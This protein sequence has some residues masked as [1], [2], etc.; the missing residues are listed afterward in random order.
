MRCCSPSRWW[1]S[2]ARTRWVWRRRRRSWSVRGSAPAAGC[3]S[4]TLPRSRASARIATVV[5]DK[6]GTLTK[7]EPEVTDVVVTADG[8]REDGAAR[9]W[10]PRW[11][12]SPSIR[13][14]R[15]SS[16]MP[17]AAR[18]LAWPRDR[19]RERAR[20]RRGRHAS[21]AAGWLSATRRLMEREGIDLGG[22][23]GRRGRA[24]RRRA[25]RG[26][27]GRRRR[28]GRADR[29]RRRT[30]ARPPRAAVAA[31]HGLGRRGRSC[32]PATTRHRRPDRRRTRHRQ[33]HRR[34]AAR[35]QGRQGR[36]A[37]AGRSEGGHGG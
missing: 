17:T 5:M 1:S 35:R 3:C 6:T 8:C 27:G 9:P 36:R 15:R 37:A 11:S 4:R 29:D 30:R 32:S 20:S 13:W 25:H 19:L 7:G 33:R 23:A 14:R 10:R 28:G 24:G 2:P 26:H 12:G 22:L 16:A 31:L 18:S 34:G 21:T